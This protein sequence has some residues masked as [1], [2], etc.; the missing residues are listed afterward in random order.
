M[1]RAEQNKFNNEIKLMK[2]AFDND[3]AEYLK[4]LKHR[5][6]LLIENGPGRYITELH[7]DCLN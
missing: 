5:E 2:Q 4:K 7:V 1:S 6:Q 3:M